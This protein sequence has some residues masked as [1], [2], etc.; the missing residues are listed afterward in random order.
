MAH[1][2]AVLHCIY[3]VGLTLNLNKCHFFK[4]TVDYLGHVIRPGQ[5]SVVEKNTVALK[6]MTHPT[7]QTDLRSF[8]GLCN[9]YRRFVK[10]FAKISAP[11]N[12]LLRKGERPLSSARCRRNRCLPLTRSVL[13]FCIR[14]FS[15]YLVSRDPVPW[16]QMP[17]IIK[18]DAVSYKS[19]RMEHK[20][21]S[22]TGVAV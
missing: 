6:D 21:R 9:V 18:W 7:T 16:I 12:I 20:T 3:R 2:D 17:L 1:L 4:D 13:R 10:G 14:P 8:L 5:L 19:N 15:P 11:L 22:V